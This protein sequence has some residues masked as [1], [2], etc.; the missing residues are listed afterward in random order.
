MIAAG[1]LSD[2]PKW[3]EVRNLPYL[4]AVIKE[5]MRI[6]PVAQW[7][8]DRVVPHGGATID[9]KY[10]PQGT[11]VGCHADSIHRNQDLFGPDADDFRPQ[12]WI[13]ASEQQRAHME[14]AMLGFGAGKRMCLGSHIAWLE[15]KKLV[16]LLVMHLDVRFVAP[17]YVVQLPA[18]R[19]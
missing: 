10:L 18:D 17:S 12:R 13:K 2:P 11:V 4:D 14:R 15:M 19:A 7:G 3:E 9:G 6:F 1:R 8:Q 5:A 16:P